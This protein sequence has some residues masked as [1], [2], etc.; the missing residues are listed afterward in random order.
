[1]KKAGKRT[2]ICF[3]ILS[4]GITLL[5]VADPA[6]AETVRGKVFRRTPSGSYPAPS[7]RLTLYGHDNE[8]RSAPVFSGNDGT[9]Y[10]HSIPPGNYTLEVWLDTNRSMNYSLQVRSSPY[11]DIGPIYIP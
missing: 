7:I 6:S 11:T 4:L 10:F 2:I 1:M 5:A 9:Y 8:G 3:L